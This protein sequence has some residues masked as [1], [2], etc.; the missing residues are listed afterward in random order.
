[1]EE[2]F[3]DLESSISLQKINIRGLFGKFDYDISL[4]NPERV[5]ILYGLKMGSEKLRFLK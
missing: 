1:M 2:I 4:E 5:T 3:K